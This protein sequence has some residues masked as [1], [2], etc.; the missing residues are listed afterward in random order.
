MKTE[1]SYDE[2]LQKLDSYKDGDTL[3]IED[4]ID[5][6][7]IISTLSKIHSNDKVEDN[8]D[9]FGD[10]LNDIKQHAKNNNHAIVMADRP[11]QLRLGWRCENTGKTWSIKIGKLREYIDKLGASDE[12]FNKRKANILRDI[13]ATQDGKKELLDAINDK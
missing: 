2:A 6:I 13:F 4:T 11:T 10:M 7:D 8:W 12:E 5:T 3:S 9:D 1:I